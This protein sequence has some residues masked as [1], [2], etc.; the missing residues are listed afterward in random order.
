MNYPAYI[1]QTV[2]VI[3][4]LLNSKQVALA[5]KM[6]NG[7][8]DYYCGGALINKQ[9][10]L[11]AAHCIEKYVFLHFILFSFYILIVLLS[12]LSH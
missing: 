11:T 5:K 9:Y 8:N 6:Q 3:F 12:K 10:V 4:T 2:T 7:N 1:F